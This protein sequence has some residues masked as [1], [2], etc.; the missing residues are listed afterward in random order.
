MSD[1]YRKYPHDKETGTSCYLKHA[2]GRKQAKINR[3]RNK[4]IPPDPWDPWEEVAPNPEL[5]IPFHM[6]E[7]MLEKKFPEE[8]IIKKL[9]SKFKFSYKEAKQVLKSVSS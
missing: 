9:K 5:Y 1:T 6:A 4:S 2:K 7:R 3:A 8:I